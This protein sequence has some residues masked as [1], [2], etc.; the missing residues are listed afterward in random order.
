MNKSIVII[1]GG[2]VGLI[3]GLL[4]QENSIDTLILESKSKLQSFNDQ[5]ALA[6][7]NG[8]RFILEKVGI[9]KELQSKLTDIKS[10]HT[11]QKGTFGR[12]LMKAKEF[13]QDA[14]GYIVAY[15]DLIKL[16]HIKLKQAKKIKIL[17]ESK[18]IKFTKKKDKSSLAYQAKEITYKLD[19]DFLVLADGGYSSIPGIN[20]ERISKSFN[21]SAIVTKVT[22]EFPHQNIAYERFIKMGPIALL[23]NLNNKF[24]LVWTGGADKISKLKKLNDK[25]FLIEL[26]NYF[27]DRVGEFISCENRTTFPLT[28]SY[29]NHNDNKNIVVIGNSAQIIHPVAGQGLNTGLRD[30]FTLSSCI[31]LNAGL[32][33]INLL[34]IKYNKLRKSETKNIM[35]FTE[36]LVSGFSNDI[37]GLNIA[38]GLA[39]SFLDLTPK[40][41]KVF[42]RKM[43]IGR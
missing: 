38:R 30:A 13:D 35:R 4:N 33:D 31:K 8:S 19:M 29:V 32:K 11:S 28:Q 12:T 6:L 42:V 3:F 2:P 26:H 27:G 24:S 34:L 36:T 14:L 39:L 43:S 20:I 25:D 16:L 10:I 37:V 41:K 15:G 18:A 21:H 5:R 17:F 9:W 23:P 22:S 1:G 40:I 7:S